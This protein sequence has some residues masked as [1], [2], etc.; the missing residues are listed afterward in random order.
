M[1]LRSA[2]GFSEMNIRAVLVVVAATPAAGE[3]V[4]GID[5][6]IGLNDVDHL[7]QDLVHGLEGSVLVGHDRPDHASVVLL[8]EESLG[9]VDEQINV[10][11]DGGQ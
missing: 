9:H 10:Q 8:R 2:S 4:D 3:S 7:Q 6:R 5:R 1:I 11:R